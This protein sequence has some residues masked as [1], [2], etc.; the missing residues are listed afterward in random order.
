MYSVKHTHYLMLVGG[1]GWVER[2]GRQRKRK[3]RVGGGG[4]EGL[5]DRE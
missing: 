3:G 4:G 2:R 5:M 1:T